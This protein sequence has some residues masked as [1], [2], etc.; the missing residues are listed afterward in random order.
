MLRRIVP[1]YC[2]AALEAAFIAVIRR[3]Q[4]TP[5]HAK[6]QVEEALAKGGKLTALAALAFFDDRGKGGEVMARVNKYGPWAGDAFKQC[7]EGTHKEFAGDLQQLIKDTTKLTE[8]VMA[9]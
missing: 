4:L 2:R 1:G 3:R 5:G 8:R 6:D 9:L 7:N